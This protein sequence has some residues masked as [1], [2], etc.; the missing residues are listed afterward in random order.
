MNR[1]R[2]ILIGALLAVLLVIA[3]GAYLISTVDLNEYV[4]VI[5]AQAKARTGRQLK[6]KGTMTKIM[7]APKA[8][9]ELVNCC[10]LVETQWPG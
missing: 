10:T 9:T 3:A 2:K 6:L 1:V 5:E 7:K 4:D 8:A